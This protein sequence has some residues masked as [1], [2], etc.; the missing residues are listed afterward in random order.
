MD[1]A[2]LVHLLNV[3]ALIAIM[4]SIGLTVTFEEV[5]A[6][7]RHIRLVVLG[8]VANFVLVPLV[9]AGLLYVFQTPPLVSAGFLILAVCPGAPVGPTFTSI[10]KGDVSL[11]TG[12][13]VILAGLSAA[14]APALL[15]VLLGWLS[16]ESP[17]GNL[18]I[19]YLQIAGT[20]LITQI[21]PLGIGLGMHEWAPGL[22][23][24]LVKPTSLVANVLLLAVVGLIL[25]TQYQTLGAFRLRGWLGMLLLL[26]AS[27]GIGWLCGGTAQPARR[28]MAVTTGV[29][30]AAV[31][32]VIVSA[33]FAG[34]PAVT[35]VVAYAL[36]SIFGTL[37]CAFLLGKFT[38]MPGAMAE[39]TTE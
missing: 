35:A 3:I 2:T 22:S 23:G 34:T 21:I 18:D 16:P 31:G 39:G 8:L 33:N 13:M 10:A 24:W 26:A 14:L 28:A 37:A 4:L 7:A 5:L 29:R 17:E 12:L 6:S 38:A 11:A 1:T 32:L 27:L 36:V 19:E 15:T 9:T 30:N 20:L 25:A